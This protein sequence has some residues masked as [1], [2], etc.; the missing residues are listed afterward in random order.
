MSGRRLCATEYVEATLVNFSDLKR[1]RSHLGAQKTI[2][3]FLGFVVNS[4][5]LL[6]RLSRGVALRHGHFNWRATLGV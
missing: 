3:H 2:S 4:L 6:H 1:D 5:K